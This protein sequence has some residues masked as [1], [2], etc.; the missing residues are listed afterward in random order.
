MEDPRAMRS[1]LEAAFV[2]KSF[3]RIGDHARNLARH[4]RALG[5]QARAEGS[6][7]TA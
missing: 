2:M 4:V 7:A 5:A 6:R 3:E 1:V